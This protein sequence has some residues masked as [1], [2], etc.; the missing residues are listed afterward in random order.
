MKCVLCGGALQNKV[1]EEEVKVENNHYLV[2]MEVEAC[3]DCGERYYREGQID[4]LIQWK[5]KLKDS[6]SQYQEIGKVYQVA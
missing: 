6:G 3:Q 1:V 4:E 5:K 2:K